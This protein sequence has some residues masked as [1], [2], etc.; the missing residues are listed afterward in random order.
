MNFKDSSFEINKLRKISIYLIV[1]IFGLTILNSCGFYRP[2]DARKIPQTAAEKRRQNIDEGRGISLKNVL[3]S[4]GTNYEFSTSNPMWRAS[5]EILDFLP[6]TT[7]DYS[8]GIIITDWYSNNQDKDVSLKLTVRFLSNEV[9]TNSIRIIVHQ[10]KCISLTNCSTTLINSKI[11]EEL[12]K[13]ILSR[14]ALIEK[15]QKKK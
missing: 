14:A 6:L 3:G 8:G 2:V 4:R 5:L 7:V 9:K 13:S 11:T 10:K 1:L 15:D 12:T